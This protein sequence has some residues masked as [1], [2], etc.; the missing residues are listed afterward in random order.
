MLFAPLVLALP[1]VVL[2]GEAVIFKVAG[3]TSRGRM[4]AR[5]S[6]LALIFMDADLAEVKQLYWDCRIKDK[7]VVE[8]CGRGRG[9]RRGQPGSCE[10]QVGQRTHSTRFRLMHQRGTR[11][12]M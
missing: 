4:T 11:C 6:E 2:H 3:V 7:V 12:G 10:R 9:T 5:V 8:G 1:L